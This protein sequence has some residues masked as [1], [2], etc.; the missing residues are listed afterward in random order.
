MSKSTRL[1]EDTWRTSSIILN[2]SDI[3]RDFLNEHYKL[4]QYKV[5]EDFHF[6]TADWS[7]KFRSLHTA[8]KE[9]INKPYYFNTKSRKLFV[10]YQLDD[11]T[12]DFTL[13]FL[14]INN[15]K[16]ESRKI[17]FEWIYSSDLLKLFL[18]DYFYNEIEAA[19]RICQSNYF[20]IGEKSANFATALRLTL[21]KNYGTKNEFFVKNSAK[22][23]VKC[24][25]KDKD[26]SYQRYE[27]VTFNGTSYFRQL[28]QS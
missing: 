19:R 24:K 22:K 9:Q 21:S 15:P 5:H 1:P 7:W 17:P 6:H 16:C 14:S 20:V 12:L 8:Y 10:L 25:K 13:D 26:T 11:K 28:R 2:E 27:I 4:V 23:F 18:S 3:D